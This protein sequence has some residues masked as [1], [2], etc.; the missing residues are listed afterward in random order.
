M[1]SEPRI[2]GY[3]M[4]RLLKKDK[5]CDVQETLIRERAES[6]D[7]RWSGC[8]RDQDTSGKVVPFLTRNGAQQLM[9][10]LQ[11]GDHVVVWKLDR[12]GHHLAHILNTIMVLTSR[13][14]H[15]HVIDHDGHHLDL[16]EGSSELFIRILKPFARLGAALTSE[17]TKEAM[18]RRKESGLPVNAY[19]PW[20]M[21]RTRHKSRDGTVLKF[22][23]WH[24]PECQQIREICRRANTGESL[25]SIARDFADR[26]L[27]TANRKPWVPRR[28]D[29]H[30]INSTRIR[31]TYRW[32]C[33]LREAGMEVGISPP[34]EVTKFTAEWRRLGRPKTLRTG[35]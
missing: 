19:S 31:E 32:A 5:P 21:R 7:G 9:G 20:G 25:S 8:Y 4:A 22:D 26:K 15:V 17:L 23:I 11:P 18:T 10:E 2:F 6:I 30:G 3:A 35:G 14:A 27:K 1:N 24:E 12:L 33:C 34:E 29:K 28:K 16:D 13:G